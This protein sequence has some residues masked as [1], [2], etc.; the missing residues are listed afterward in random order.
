M[1]GFHETKQGVRYTISEPARLE[2]LARLLNLNHERHA[3]E[4]KHG[5]H[6]KKREAGS[7]VPAAATG[8]LLT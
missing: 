3:E 5:L 7:D 8:G 6:E 2:I 4:V 1:Y